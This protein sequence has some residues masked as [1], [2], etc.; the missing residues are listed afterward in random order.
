MALKRNKQVKVQAGHKRAT[1]ADTLLDFFKV[2]NEDV[3]NNPVKLNL[4]DDT[5]AEEHSKENDNGSQE[6]KEEMTGSRRA[7]G[8]DPKSMSEDELLNATLEDYKA[9]L[10]SS[11]ENLEQQQAK[12][13]ADTAGAEANSQGGISDIVSGTSTGVGVRENAAALPTENGSSSNKGGTL[14]RENTHELQVLAE[15]RELIKSASSNLHKPAIDF[16]NKYKNIEQRH[17][18][19]L[20]ENRVNDVM[21]KPIAYD[22]EYPKQQA[23]ISPWPTSSQS[24]DSPAH[25]KKA[26]TQDATTAAVVTPSSRDSDA[27]EET[28]DQEATEMILQRPMRPTK[29]TVNRLKGKFRITPP[30]RKK[31]K[32]KLY[33]KLSKPTGNRSGQKSG[34][35]KAS[36]KNLGRHQNDLLQ[37]LM[38]KM[39]NVKEE[40]DEEQ[41]TQDTQGLAL[42][43]GVSLGAVFQG[44]LP[45]KGK[46]SSPFYHLQNQSSFVDCL[47]YLYPLLK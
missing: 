32:N 21:I 34:K 20:G 2:N 12:S 28:E 29:S 22:E 19:G 17:R 16:M 1:N 9:L 47:K 24:S 25:S 11:K 8:I 33:Q 4:D 39:Q 42:T 3:I 40:V 18:T 26:P 38:Q 44:E 37:T 6:H 7:E 23:S 15:I 43:G 46:F 31:L 27:K 45:K 30:T 36:V 5:N 10:V 14:S 35:A 41:N 13:S